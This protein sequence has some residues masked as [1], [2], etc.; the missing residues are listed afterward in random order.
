MIF[1]GNNISE[2]DTEYLIPI[3]HDLIGGQRFDGF[4]SE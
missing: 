3:G 1:D 2:V 4:A